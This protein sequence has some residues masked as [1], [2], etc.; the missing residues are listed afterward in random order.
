MSINLNGQATV[1]L[2]KLNISVS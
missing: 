1:H 2:S